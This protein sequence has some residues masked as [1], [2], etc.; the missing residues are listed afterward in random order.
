MAMRASEL[1]TLMAT[2]HLMVRSKIMFILGTTAIKTG[3][4]NDLRLRLLAMLEASKNPAPYLRSVEMLVGFMSRERNIESIFRSRH[5]IKRLPQ[6]ERY[7]L[8]FNE[9]ILRIRQAFR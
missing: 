6:L 5:R 8:Q 3:A 7:D 9:I 4:D 1:E 2:A